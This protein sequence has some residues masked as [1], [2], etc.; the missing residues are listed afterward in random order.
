MILSYVGS[1]LEVRFLNRNNIQNIKHFILGESSIFDVHAQQ[2]TQK[3]AKTKQ[4][5]TNNQAKTKQHFFT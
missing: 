4:K 3:K 5:Q 2:K 1:N